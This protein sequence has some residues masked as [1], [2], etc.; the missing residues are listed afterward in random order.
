MTCN[1][2]ITKFEFESK[3]SRRLPSPLDEEHAQNLRTV[4]E[5]LLQHKFY[6]KLKKCEIWLS[7][8]GFLGHMINQHGISVDPNEISIVVDWAR[9]T[10]VKEV[11]SFLG[12]P[13]DYCVFWSDQADVGQFQISLG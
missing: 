9:P 13:G 1:L 7:E 6:A 5:T 4:L 2:V 11:R 10:N 12:F 8:V 3:I